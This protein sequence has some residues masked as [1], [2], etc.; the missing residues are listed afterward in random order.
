MCQ[1]LS[2]MVV[3]LHEQTIYVLLSDLNTYF[4]FTGI[5]IW[6]LQK[7]NS[8]KEIQLFWY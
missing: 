8:Q 7:T 1:N 3:M 5:I 6:R 2:V 4:G